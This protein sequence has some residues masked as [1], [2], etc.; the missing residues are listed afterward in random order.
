MQVKGPIVHFDRRIE[1]PFSEE[2]PTSGIRLRPGRKTDG[3]SLNAF[4]EA[5]GAEGNVK[6]WLGN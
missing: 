5:E 4:E 3:L 1:F 2:L 6:G